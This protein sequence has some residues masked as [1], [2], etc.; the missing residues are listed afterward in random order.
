MHVAR[1]EASKARLGKHRD[2]A[3]P[4]HRVTSSENISHYCTTSATSDVAVLVR[5]P[6]CA[7]E[8]LQN[9]AIRKR[10]HLVPSRYALDTCQ[11]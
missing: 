4:S 3:S 6:S 8:E 10:H 7:T 5:R 1:N 9:N 11:A 2:G